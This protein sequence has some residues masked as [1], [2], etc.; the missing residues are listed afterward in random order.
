MSAPVSVGRIVQY[1]DDRGYH[2]AAIVT[3]VHPTCLGRVEVALTVLPPAG[4]APCRVGVLPLD[5]VPD[6]QVDHA[7]NTWHWPERV[8]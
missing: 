6:D 8:E 1:V 5:H 3:Q 4:R 7:A 2:N